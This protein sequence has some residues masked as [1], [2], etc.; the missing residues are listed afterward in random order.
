MANSQHI[1]SLLPS[2]KARLIED[3]QEIPVDIL[4]LADDFIEEP[5]TERPDSKLSEPKVIDPEQEEERKAE[6]AHNVKIGELV[7]KLTR[8][9]NVL[10]ELLPQSKNPQSNDYLNKAH[11]LIMNFP[12]P[13][14]ELLK[15]NTER[16]H[17][18]QRISDVTD[19]NAFKRRKS[20]KRLRDH[21]KFR[22]D[23]GA[24]AG[25]GTLQYY[26]YLCNLK[27]ME[28]STPKCLW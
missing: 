17:K 23:P 6:E 21:K 15:K 22:G 2:L 12:M 8:L 4:G 27:I 3:S 10:P 9:K 14:R 20:D 1:V 5:F 11:D 28:N 19:Y 26:I 7:E 18:P 25:D 16:T 24:L 13:G